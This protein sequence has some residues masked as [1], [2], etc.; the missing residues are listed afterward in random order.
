MASVKSHWLFAPSKDFFEFNLKYLTY[1][2]LWPKEDWSKPQRFLFEIYSMTLSVFEGVFLI[3]TSIGTYNCKNDITALLTNLDKILVVYNF[4]M[5]ALI[6][7]IKR[8]QI[9][10]LIDEI[11][12]S[13]DEITMSRNRMMSV[14]VVV[15]SVLVISIV[16]A[17]SLLATYKQEM[18]IEAWM[19]FDPLI[20]KKHLILASLIL[21]VLFVPCACRAMAIQG[22]VCSILMYLCDQL[23][24]LQIRIR[25]LDYRPE[26]HK[27][28]RVDF[29]EVIKKHVR[30]IGRFFR[31]SNTLRAIFKE[32]FLFQ[33]LA[34]TVELCFNAM[35]VTMVG[36]KEKTLLLTFFAYLSVALLNSYIYCFLADE[37]IVQ[38]QGIALAAYESQWT[39]WPV[40]L[41]KDILIIILVAQRPLTLSAGGMATMSIQTF[42]QTLYNGYSIFAVLSDVVD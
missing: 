32:Y 5:K 22:I 25:A 7:F 23:I 29:N 19:A 18:T 17:F 13:K 34:V 12:H 1:L 38:S 37:L 2:G 4:V 30:L 42:G 35:M 6:F 3:L 21:A 39:T 41:Q 15:I 10:I 28:M 26:T 33:N 36:F 27:Q 20:D 9:K 11:K 14:H 31:Y 24:E 16:S 40:E 8:K